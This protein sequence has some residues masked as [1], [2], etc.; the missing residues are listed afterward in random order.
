MS[1]TVAILKK[2]ALKNK[3]NSPV[4]K[5]S[6]VDRAQ[7]LEYNILVLWQMFEY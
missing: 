3:K 6:K 4:E 2:M 7:K 5:A 1:D